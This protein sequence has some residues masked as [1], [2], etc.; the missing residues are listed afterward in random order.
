MLHLRVPVDPA[1][2]GPRLVVRGA[3]L[4]P[5]VSG[6]KPPA[7]PARD[8]VL[9]LTTAVRVGRDRTQCPI[10]VEGD[11]RVSRQHLQF[12]IVAG[13]ASVQD[14]A[15]TNGSLLN[16]KPVPPLKAIPLKA[17]DE[18]QIGAV[19]ILYLA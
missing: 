2:K 18:V 3:S 9:P 14:L 12:S 19:K 16:G 10:A 17:G 8:V 7:Q 13:Q 6:S 4:P 1:C 11:R 5:P 15:S